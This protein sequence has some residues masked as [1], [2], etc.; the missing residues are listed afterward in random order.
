LSIGFLQTRLS[1]VEQ[2][3]GRPRDTVLIRIEREFNVNPEWLRTGE[4]EVF[5]G[6]PPIPGTVDLSG[7]KLIPVY[8]MA[9]AG[10]RIKLQEQEPIEWIAV[11]EEDAKESIIAVKVR[12]K[13]MEP[14]IR[15]GA[16]C[17]F[18]TERKDII[19]GDIYLLWRNYEGAVIRRLFVQK[20]ALLLKPDNPTFP[21]EL[22]SI[23]ETN[24][25]HIVGKF[26]WVYYR[27]KL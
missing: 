27:G 18:D 19:S 20:K 14:T 24:D 11:P 23:E 25:V 1:E 15:E 2:G 26:V 3:K 12:G 10:E 5:L 9:G 22:I 13:S 6:H 16:I 7:F 21:E 8:Q 17:G 4:G